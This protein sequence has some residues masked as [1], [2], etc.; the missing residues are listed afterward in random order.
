VRGLLRSLA[1]GRAVGLVAVGTGLVLGATYLPAPINV[2][3][4]TSPPAAMGTHAAPVTATQSI[5]PG[6]EALGI[7]GVTDSPAQTVWVAGVAAPVASLPSGFVSGPGDGSL[8]MSGLPSG[9]QWAAPVAERGQVVSGQL[10]T[11]RSALVA[12][13]GAMAPGTVAT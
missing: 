6:P 3:H 13:A 1:L 11:A 2:G 4:G 5:C 12:G 8:T 9:G 7:E 10:S